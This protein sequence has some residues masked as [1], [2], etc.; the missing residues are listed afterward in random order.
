MACRKAVRCSPRFRSQIIG[1]SSSVSVQGKAG[2]SRTI[3]NK[4][5]WRFAR[6]SVRKGDRVRI[7]AEL[8]N[9]ADGR[10]LVRT[11]DRELKDVFAVQAKDRHC[12]DRAAQ[13]KLSGAVKLG[14][15][16]ER[17]SRRL[18]RVTAGTFYFRRKCE[19]D[20]QSNRFY[21]E[22]VSSIALRARLCNLS[23]AWR[24]PGT[25]WL[26]GGARAKKLYQSEER[27]PNCL[28]ARA[29]SLGC[30]RPRLRIAHMDIDF[31]DRSRTPRGEKRPRL[32]LGRRRTL[33]SPR[34]E[35][36]WRS[37]RTWRDG[38][39]LSIRWVWFA[40]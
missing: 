19:E 10:T 30:A 14:G 17:Q 4:Q 8:I 34:C 38:R 15:A 31:A 37:R 21:G 29:R 32:T 26:G 28:V 18:Q 40:I 16:V 23:F 1:R 13:I 6:G 11:R 36:G 24:S 9:A 27:S 35:A 3:G 2:G 39:W 20:A 33:Y 12:G 7:V 5:A 25:T 22:A